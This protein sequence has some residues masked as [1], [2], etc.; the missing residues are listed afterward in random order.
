M[1]WF[2]WLV[3][4]LNSCQ[5]TLTSHGQQG[6]WAEAGWRLA[7]GT[8]CSLAK[9]VG[10]AS[11]FCLGLSWG[12][13]AVTLANP[14][15]SEEAGPAAVP[16]TSQRPEGLTLHLR[17]PLLIREDTCSPS[18][19]GGTCAAASPLLAPR[20][21]GFLFL[22]RDLSARGS[23]LC[24]PG[25][26]VGVGPPTSGSVAGCGVGSLPAG[27]RGPCCQAACSPSLGWMPETDFILRSPP[28]LGS[29][30]QG[31]CRSPD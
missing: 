6:D 9:A 5:R 3:K 14:P 19:L 29:V 24:A 13:R 30:F 2:S 23:A 28:S 7:D 21:Q 4:V 27:G 11:A 10:A 12:L 8:A 31:S 17:P 20:L 1:S 22:A 18:F 26:R 25:I 16:P 15:G